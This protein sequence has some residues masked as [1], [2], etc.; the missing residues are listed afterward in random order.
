M[1][2]EG[3]GRTENERCVRQ[4]RSRC[5]YDIEEQK[6][7]LQNCVKGDGYYWHSESAINCGKLSLQ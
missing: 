4:E 1:A 7:D 2:K 5:C 3:T 6:D